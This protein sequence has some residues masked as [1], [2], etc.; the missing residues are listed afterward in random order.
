MVRT[1][2]GPDSFVA[3]TATIGEEYGEDP[4][5][6]KIG[7][8]AAV[9]GGTV[10]YADVAVG[11]DF[12]TG[13]NAVVREQTT[14]GDDVLVGTNA[15]V[16]GQVDL[17]S[18]V[19]LQTGVYLP[20][21]TSVGDEVFFGPHAVVTNDRHPIRSTDSLAGATI[22]DHVSIGANAVVLPGVTVESGSFVAAGAV[23]TQDVP[24]DTLAVGTP[25]EYRPLP[26]ELE[27]GNLI[28]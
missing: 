21:M 5:P 7:A 27:G 19:S 25:A 6:T 2:I 22:E 10:V 26:A 8:N 13:H 1:T 4:G 11:D 17:G 3:E 15:V 12:T 23:V 14:A 20:P 24:P 16:D 18:H 28:A 9:R